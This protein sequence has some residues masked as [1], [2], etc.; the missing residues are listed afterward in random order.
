V[1]SKLQVLRIT[2]GGLSPRPLVHLRSLL[3]EHTRDAY[4][5]GGLPAVFLAFATGDLILGQVSHLDAFSG[6]LCQT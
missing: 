2:L 1:A 4:I 6:Y 5:A 3:A